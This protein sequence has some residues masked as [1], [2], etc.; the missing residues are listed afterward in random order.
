[1]TKELVEDIMRLETDAEHQLVKA[2]T[3]KEN[4]IIHARKQTLLAV[5]EAEH[6]LDTEREERI[7]EHDKTMHD[8]KITLIEDA[9]Q[10]ARELASRVEPRIEPAA[11]QVLQRFFE[12]T[13]DVS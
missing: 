9:K 2:A 1:M 12:Y 5:Q 3:E 4:I 11:E 6:T 13:H 10:E 8:R 7:R